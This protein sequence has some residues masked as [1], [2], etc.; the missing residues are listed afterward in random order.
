MQILYLYRPKPGF[1]DEKDELSVWQCK[2]KVA[3][4]PFAVINITNLP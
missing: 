4:I 2:C 3:E 1:A